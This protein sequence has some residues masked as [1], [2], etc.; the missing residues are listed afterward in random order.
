MLETSAQQ[1]YLMPEALDGAARL[2]STERQEIDDQEKLGM[3]RK[4]VLGQDHSPEK[5]DL[6]L[7]DNEARQVQRSKLKP[8]TKDL[9]Q[10]QFAALQYIRD[11]PHLFKLIQGPPG[12]GKSTLLASLM[13]VCKAFNHLTL[14]CAPSNTAVNELV[15]K[16]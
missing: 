7:F 14:F 4:F 11:S 16:I 10:A 8:W 9:N 6:T 15:K 13:G 5:V 3:V 2:M 1:I 12:T